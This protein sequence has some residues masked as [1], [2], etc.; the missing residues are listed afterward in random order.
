MRVASLGKARRPS[1]Q[2]VAALYAAASLEVIARANSQGVKCAV[3]KGRIGSAAIVTPVRFFIETVVEILSPNCQVV[4]R[5]EFGSGAGDESGK[6][7]VRN[8]LIRNTVI[9]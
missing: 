4:G 1:S 3:G 9:A 5:F 8:D 2:P 6:V 7:L